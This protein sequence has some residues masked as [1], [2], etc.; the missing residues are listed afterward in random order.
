M[1]NLHTKVEVSML[2]HY[3]ISGYGSLGYRQHNHSKSAYDFVL[4][5]SRNHRLSCI[6]FELQPLAGFKGSYFLWH[7][8]RGKEMG[9]KGTF[10]VH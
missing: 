1:I 5:F 6:M 2:T 4:N 3:V 8:R 10:K 7:G 9:G